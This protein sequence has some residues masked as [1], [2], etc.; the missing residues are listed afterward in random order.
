MRKNLFAVVLVCTLTIAGLAQVTTGR[1]QGTVTDAQG[2]VVPGAQIK[3]VNKLT[4]QTFDA[5]TN[6]LGVW[7]LPSMPTST[8]AVTVSLAGFKSVSIDNVKVD[9]G[10]PATVNARLDV[11][12]VSEEVSVETGAEV[13]QTETATLTSTLVGQQLHE[14]PFTSRNLTELIVT[15][16]GSA[17]PGVP[18]STSVYGL[19]QSAMNVTLDGLN[20]QDNANKSGD[21]FFN[22]IFP[23]AEAIEEMT[24]SSAAAGADSN[25]EGA[26]S[27]KMVTRS[28]SNVWHGGLF[29]QHR[30]E[31]FNANGYFNN[32]NH[33]P[34]DHMVFNQFGGHVGGPVLRNKLFFF[35]HYEV[36]RLPQTYNSPAVTVLTPEAMSGL[37][38]Y[39]DTA[40]N[41]R[42][43]NLYQIAAA[44]GLPSTPDPLIGASLSKIADLTNGA[45]GL[46]SRIATN[47]D[48]NRNSLDFQSKGGNYRK[49]GTSRFDYN[50][51]DKHHVEFIY[52]YQTNVRRPDGIN[53]N[54][55][56]PVFP[57]TGAVLGSTEL[58]NQGGIAFSAVTALRS[59]LS[60]RLVSEVRFGLTGGIVIFNNN[61][62]PGDFDQWRGFAPSFGVIGANVY[63]TNPFRSTGQTRRNT[64]LKQ[65]N[66]NF[67]YSMTAHLL[68]FGGSFTQVNAWT[69]SNNGTQIVPTIGFGVATGDPVITGSTNI[70]N[71][72]NFPGANATDMQ[73]NAP[74]LYALFATWGMTN[75]RRRLI[76]ARRSS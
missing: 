54:T 66:T 49:F 55:A 1:I 33:Q 6:E 43:V 19:P 67:T 25:A 9:A 8:Y 53:I 64:P 32:L 50:V 59:T 11:G 42:S 22:N 26:M 52:N 68:N 58:G 28:G 14:L 30:N 5:L 2:G 34:R 75:R 60:S 48:Y 20:I 29:E 69:S 13:L 56:S 47:A 44:G 15:Q 45:P 17:T 37:F 24:I 3:V 40:G 61:I 63:V 7:A 65:G 74:A 51:T 36:F 31:K 21:G 12:N 71:A 41:V 72:T 76:F 10:V 23:R 35:A 18:R 46:K 16:P 73:T 38:R 70:F 39:R 57:G 4:G 62:N 27:I